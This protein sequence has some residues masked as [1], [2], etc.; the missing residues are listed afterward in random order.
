MSTLFSN[1]S[2]LALR[3]AREIDR[4]EIR[5]VEAAKKYGV[6]RETI[7]AAR[8]VLHTADDETLAAID[9]GELRVGGADT[10]AR[11]AREAFRS[12]FA[13]I[14]DLDAADRTEV[15]NA[16]VAHLRGLGVEVAP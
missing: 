3:A 5:V 16:V 2:Q 13:R 14:K 1:P 6:T 9:R 11:K 15:V 8:R 7:R 12:A 10:K 4:G